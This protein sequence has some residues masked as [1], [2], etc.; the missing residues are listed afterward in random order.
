MGYYINAINGVAAPSKDKARF[1]L[2][3]S[4]GAEPIEPPTKWQ[5]GLV[6]VVD[7]G[8]FEAAG[9]AFD[10]DEMNVFLRP[11]SGGRQRHRQWLLVPEA[12]ALS[13]YKD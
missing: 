1:I 10:E 9:Y 3:R 4:I 8:A 2:T 12:K 5:E 6:C 11:D 7:N 13:G